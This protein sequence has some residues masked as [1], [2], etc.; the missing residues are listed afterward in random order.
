MKKSKTKKQNRIS[1]LYHKKIA[2]DKDESFI[3]Q[4]IARKTPDQSAIMVKDDI[5][6]I[7]FEESINKNTENSR[8]AIVAKKIGGNKYKNYFLATYSAK[9]I[10]NEMNIKKEE[11]INGQNLN[12]FLMH[13][14]DSNKDHEKLFYKFIKRTYGANS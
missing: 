11:K 5:R 7:I 2:I 13:L 1:I 8:Y 3:V 14:L 12:D 9:F 6:Y 10:K 4:E